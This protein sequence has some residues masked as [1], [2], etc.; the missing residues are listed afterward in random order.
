MLDYC[1][2]QAY[3]YGY[4]LNNGGATQRRDNMRKLKYEG[5]FGIGDKIKALDF[6]GNND[7][8][9][10]GKIIAT[11]TVRGAK[12]FEIDLNGCPIHSFICFLLS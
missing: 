10:A 5:K 8:W 6:V 4:V 11:S 2:R 3:N 12:V 9:I 7:Y 1:C